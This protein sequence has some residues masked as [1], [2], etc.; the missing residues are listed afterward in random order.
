MQLIHPALGICIMGSSTLTSLLGSWAVLI[1]LCQFALC[2]AHFLSRAREGQGLFWSYGSAFTSLVP[3]PFSLLFLFTD[4]AFICGLH[5]VLFS[6]LPFNLQSAFLMTL[7]HPHRILTKF[8]SSV[9]LMVE[10]WWGFNSGNMARNLWSNQ[11]SCC[12]CCSV[13]LGRW[14]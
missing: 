3:G 7:P 4:L 1:M 8:L 12:C 6:P 11:N 2:L 10:R 5:R 14:T 9:Y 13:F